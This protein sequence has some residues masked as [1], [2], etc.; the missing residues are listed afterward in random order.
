MVDSAQCLRVVQCH[1]FSDVRVEVTYANHRS[2]GIGRFSDR[3]MFQQ[4]V[5]WEGGK[6]SMVEYYKK[7]YG[8]EL[9]WGPHFR[10]VP[11]PQ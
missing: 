6:V 11:V 3:P 8:I 4:M 7:R 10:C 5:N 1:A 9:R 2:F